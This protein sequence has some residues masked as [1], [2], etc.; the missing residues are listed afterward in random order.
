MGS[1]LGWRVSVIIVKE[2]V[3]T[4]TVVFRL[5]ATA[6][7]NVELLSVVL[8]L[9]DQSNTLTTPASSKED[10]TLKSVVHVTALLVL[11][12]LP[13]KRRMPSLNSQDNAHPRMLLT[14]TESWFAIVVLSALESPSAGPAEA[15]NCIET[16]TPM[17]PVSVG[18]NESV[19]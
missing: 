16:S 3:S 15:R 7:W 2:L 19:G 5:A 4:A 12:P 18:A 13:L 9:S 6:V 10:M 11:P 17:C 14:A 8:T 1:A